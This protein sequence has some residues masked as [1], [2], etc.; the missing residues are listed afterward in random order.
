MDS[1]PRQP[2]GDPSL[3]L[4]VSGEGRSESAVRAIARVLLATALLLSIPLLAMRFTDAVVWD[5]FDFAIMGALLIA[6]RSAWEGARRVRADVAYR[7]GV[8]LGL[9]GLFLLVWLN[10]A[11]GLIGN[12]AN[13]A[14]LMYVGVILLAVVGAA[15]AGLRPNGMERL[16]YAVAAAFVL[17]AI[18]ALGF[19]LGG[20]ASGTI[21]IL[22][23]NA[24]FIAI[25]LAAGALFHEAS[26]RKGTPIDP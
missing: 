6:T 18:V 12:E 1:D 17:I 16:M 4:S 21:E 3:P 5:A 20:P 14:N 15:I 10:L 22:G 23:V 7:T 9:L 24:F 8:G 25:F 2:A 19:G 26:L 13:P 11:V